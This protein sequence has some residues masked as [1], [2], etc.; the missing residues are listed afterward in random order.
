MVNKAI[1]GLSR[2]NL[3][4]LLR[5]KESSVHSGAVNLVSY[6]DS[7]PSAIEQQS[8]QYWMHAN[9]IHLSILF[10]FL[11]L[12][13][14]ALFPLN[15]FYLQEIQGIPVLSSSDGNCTSQIS[16]EILSRLLYL[17][18]DSLRVECFETRA[19]VPLK[20]KNTQSGLSFFRQ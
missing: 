20:N 19:L 12:G 17:T 1:K 10:I 8:I 5:V 16:D 2:Y 7:F 18:L 13:Y 11:P 3:L 9:G 6:S 15:F 14:L 4:F